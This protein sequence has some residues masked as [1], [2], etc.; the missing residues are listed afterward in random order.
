[1]IEQKTLTA[2]LPWERLPSTVS[3]EIMTV[4]NLRC[5]HCYL[6][7]SDREKKTMDLKL[8]QAIIDRV[9]PLL[10]TASEFN[11][12]SVEALMHP[13]IFT[14]IE[15]LR[16]YNRGLSLPIFSNG[17][18]L[19]DR[20]IGQLLD[21][22]IETVVFSLDGCRKTTT[23]SFKTG[24]D[25]ERITNNIKKLS[26]AS[27][28][29]LNI[30][31]NFVAHKN[32][33]AEIVEYVDFCRGLGVNNI[34]VTGFISYPSI[35]ESYSLYSFAGNEQVE[36]LLASAQRK[37]QGLGLGFS[38]SPTKLKSDNQF[39]RL[40]T[41]ILYIDC[42]GNVVPCNVLASKTHIA[43]EQRSTITEPVVWGN[44]LTADPE[45]LWNG[46]PY[47]WF[48]QMFYEGIL[49]VSCRLCPMAYGVIC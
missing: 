48:R 41:S 38:Y 4:C 23:E 45:A 1:M 44:V 35:L 46:K 28:G 33:I 43:F 49:P 14:M 20:L 25:F 29:R 32:N 5:H 37:A 27:K 36:D 30:T 13:H 11:F 22:A 26:L 24:S 7:H 42:D 18:I 6:Y 16:K 17:M 2:I 12:A 10:S 31:A 40:T 3:V 34:T 9:S 39:C 21:Y 8:F 47:Q 15:Y 19:N